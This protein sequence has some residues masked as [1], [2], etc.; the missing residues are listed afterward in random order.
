[1]FFSIFHFTK[2]KSITIILFAE[3]KNVHFQYTLNW[4]KLKCGG[5]NLMMASEDNII[6]ERQIIYLISGKL[7]N[8]NLE[9]NIQG[10]LSLSYSNWLVKRLTV[11]MEYCKLKYRLM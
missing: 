10:L 8:S 1:M 11:L 6:L 5:N 7:L 4:G 2:Q 3:R 9:E